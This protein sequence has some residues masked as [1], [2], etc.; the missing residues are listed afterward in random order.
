MLY[1]IYVWMQVEFHIIFFCDKN[2]GQEFHTLCQREKV[3][4]FQ[5]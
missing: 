1:Y 4:F 5:G 2:L 3:T